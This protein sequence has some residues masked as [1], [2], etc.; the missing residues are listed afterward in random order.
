MDDRHNAARRALLKRAALGLAIGPLALAR[1]PAVPA[2]E[3]PLLSEQ[4]AAAKAVHYVD[5]A[6]RAKG[7]T[8]GADCSSCSI[9]G[10]T[11]ATQGTC[12]LFPGKLVKAAGWC[13]S[14]SSL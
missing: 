9:Y 6:S 5:N 13:S 14:W 11:G 2:A 10:A 12:T 4:D 1:S 7:A 3:L 8:S